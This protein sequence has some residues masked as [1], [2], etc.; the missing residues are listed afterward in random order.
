MK[1]DIAKRERTKRIK[2]AI[3]LEVALL[4]VIGMIYVGE[5]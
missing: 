3:V 5:R 4:F 1:G 2:S